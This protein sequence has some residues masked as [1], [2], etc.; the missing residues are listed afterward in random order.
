MAGKVIPPTVGR[1]VYYYRSEAER[2]G[3]RQRGPLAAV[4]TFVHSDRLV[5]LSVMTENGETFGATAVDFVQPDKADD[6]KPEYRYCEWMP[7][8]VSQAGKTEEVAA[9]LKN[10]KEKQFQ[11]AVAKAT[12]KAHDA[13]PGT[14][15]GAKKPADDGVRRFDPAPADPATLPGPGKDA[16]PKPAWL[17]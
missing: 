13:N 16:A 17:G 8:Q 11:E 12:A 1:V 2:D 10:L 7:F 4:V 5:N 14:D 15:L 9:E 6:P 3:R